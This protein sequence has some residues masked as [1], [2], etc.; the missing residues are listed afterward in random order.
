MVN[1]TDK[2]PARSCGA[3]RYYGIALVVLAALALTGLYRTRRPAGQLA[4]DK[5]GSISWKAPGT[6]PA[7][8]LAL[9]PVE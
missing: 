8:I 9:E 3:A 1:R 6:S 7:P 4:G 2:T 5:E